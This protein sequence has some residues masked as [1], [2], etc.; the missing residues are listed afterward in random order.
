M[1]GHGEIEVLH[2]LNEGAALFV[3]QA[4]ILG[5]LLTEGGVR[6]ALVLVGRKNH[7]RRIEPEQTVEQAVIQTAPHHRW[8][9]P[10]DPLPR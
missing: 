4:W 7:Q 2:H 9:G 10:C 5:H 8:A 6:T 3:L 1:R